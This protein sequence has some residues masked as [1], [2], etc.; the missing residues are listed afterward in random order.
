M[1][2]LVGCEFSGIVRDAFRE[3]GHDAWSCDLLPTERPGPHIVGDVRDHLDGW[4]LAIFHPPCTALCRSG[5]RWYLGST[6]RTEAAAFVAELLAAPVPRI[7]VENPRTSALPRPDLVIQP[8]EYGHRET[9]A[10]CLWLRNL[11]VLMATEVWGPPYAARVHRM[12][13]TAD[14]WKNR[15]R[16]LPGIA[17]AMAEQ[18]GS[19]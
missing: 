6:Q 2:V 4:D 7:A 1:R 10:M 18:W 15:S 12:P 3:R 9:K 14:R 16:T 19:L 8:W 13:Q 5:D 11:P 17:E